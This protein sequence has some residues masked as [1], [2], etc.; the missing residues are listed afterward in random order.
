MEQKLL[1]A[2]LYKLFPTPI[3]VGHVPD[4]SICDRLEV[5]VK[6]EEQE[7]RGISEEGY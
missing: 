2:Q 6:K 7:Q 5:L 1:N 3:I 4:I